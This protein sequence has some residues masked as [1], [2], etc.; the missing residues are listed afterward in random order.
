M[1]SKILIL[2]ALFV[3]SLSF[4]QRNPNNDYLT[5]FTYK[6]KDGEVF[7]L[8]MPSVTISNLAKTMIKI[9][10]KK[11]PSKKKTPSIKTSNLKEGERFEEFLI[12]DEEI[13]FCQ[14]LSQMYK[15]TKKIS[16]TKKV[17]KI[18]FNSSTATKVSQDNLEK[19]ILE[20]LEEYN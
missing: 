10:N 6:A 18:D 1:K 20:L 2:V 7:I 9:C 5:S 15:I 17:S 11:F 13:P 12:T 16:N 3:T 19:I 8:K 4:S 14:D